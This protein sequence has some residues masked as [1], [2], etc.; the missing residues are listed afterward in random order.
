LRPSR[1]ASRVCGAPMPRGGKREG[2]GRKPGSVLSYEQRMWIGASCK[3]RYNQ[4]EGE[5]RKAEKR[6]M[7]GEGIAEELEGAWAVLRERLGEKRLAAAIQLA[8]NEGIPEEK[9]R[10]LRRHLRLIQSG[11]SRKQLLE[12]VRELRRDI[13]RG[14][15]QSEGEDSGAHDRPSFRQFRGYGKRSDVIKAVA[16]PLPNDSGLK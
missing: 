3:N 7:I 11:L 10:N 12:E 2:A 8:L 1:G 5:H 15:S 14:K 13:P 4:F 16:R 6:R 9:L